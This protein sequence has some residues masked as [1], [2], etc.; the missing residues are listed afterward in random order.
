MIYS[1]HNILG[2]TNNT[3][4]IFFLNKFMQINAK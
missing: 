2:I 3:T 4:N 1:P